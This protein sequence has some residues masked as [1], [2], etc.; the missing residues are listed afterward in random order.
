MGKMASLIDDLLGGEVSL[1]SFMKR[2]YRILRIWGKGAFMM[3]YF[4]V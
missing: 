3:F 4:A 1:V 2:K